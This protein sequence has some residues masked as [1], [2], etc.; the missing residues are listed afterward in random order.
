MPFSLTVLIISPL[1]NHSG[2]DLN[3]AIKGARPQTVPL[4]T[5]TSPAFSPEDDR[6]A[7][8]SGK[9]IRPRKF[10]TVDDFKIDKAILSFAKQK[11]TTGLLEV[12][13]STVTALSVFERKKSANVSKVGLGMSQP[14]RYPTPTRFWIA[15]GDR[16]SSFVIILDDWKFDVYAKGERK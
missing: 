8:T 10:S 9:S 13:L 5:N 15:V 12:F 4:L 14:V 11:S 1:S 3:I 16:R 7:F 6:Q 2:Q